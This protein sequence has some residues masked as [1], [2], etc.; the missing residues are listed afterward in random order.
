MCPC[1][2]PTYFPTGPSYAARPVPNLPPPGTSGLQA[3]LP[4]CPLTL[5]G[6]FSMG[7]VR[8]IFWP[9]LVSPDIALPLM[10]LILGGGLRFMGY[11]SYPLI[12]RC[13][14]DL[15]SCHCIL[16]QVGPKGPTTTAERLRGNS[17]V[18]T[19]ELRGHSSMPWGP[20]GPLI[21]FPSWTRPYVRFLW[22]LRLITGPY[23]TCPCMPFQLAV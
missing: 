12:Q 11:R 22:F 21:T 3:G 19:N 17:L 8:P 6:K 10:P 23:V 4:W 16:A 9:P 5:S 15:R 7:T 14:P 1:T 13:R 20:T 18:A 2:P